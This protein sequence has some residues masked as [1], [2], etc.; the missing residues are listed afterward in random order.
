MFIV[1]RVSLRPHH[2]RSI[3]K[4]CMGQAHAPLHCVGFSELPPL[5][6]RSG[7]SARFIWKRCLD[8]ERMI[9]CAI[10][11]LKA[12]TQTPFLHTQASVN[13]NPTLSHP[14]TPNISNKTTQHNTTPAT[15]PSTSQILFL[16]QPQR[17]PPGLFP[18]AH[19]P[20]LPHQPQ[21]II[22]RPTPPAPSL[23]L[24]PHLITE[25][26]RIVAPVVCCFRDGVAYASAGVVDV[27]A[28][29]FDDCAGCGA[30]A[31]DGG[32]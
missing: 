28:D 21:R 5:L 20:P 17:I 15:H 7:L 10:P 25:L 29:G 1:C 13:P 6:L 26:A 22:R 8:R 30:G 2:A 27:F 23:R 16:P 31:G 9:D 11:N 32:V 3:Y 19:T 12:L 18:P 24:I 14:K 4:Y